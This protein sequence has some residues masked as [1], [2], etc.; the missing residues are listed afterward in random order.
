[1]TLNIFFRLIPGGTY[2]KKLFY[3]NLTQYVGYHTWTFL[4]SMLVL[5]AVPEILKGWIMLTIQVLLTTDTHVYSDFIFLFT[6]QETRTEW[7]GFGFVFTMLIAPVLSYFW[8]FRNS[9]KAKYL[10]T[11]SYLIALSAYSIYTIF[12]TW[13]PRYEYGIWRDLIIKSNYNPMFILMAMV[14]ISFMWFGVIIS[15]GYLIWKSWKEG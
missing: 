5:S 8:A 11:I 6:T 10:R 7:I 13:D 9:K 2:K 4:L 1:M 14:E 3:W 12:F 15:N